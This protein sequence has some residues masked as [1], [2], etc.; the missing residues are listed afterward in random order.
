[1]RADRLLSILM[2]L[3]GRGKMTAQ[4]LSEALDVSERT[5][6][7]DIDA[8]CTSG[9]PVYPE[10]GPGGGFALLES[11]RTNLTGLTEGE[12][13]ALFMLNVPSPLEKLGVSQELQ[14]ALLKLEAAQPTARK[15]ASRKSGA[16]DQAQNR[17]LID[18]EGFFTE[19]PVPHLKLI[20]EAVWKNQRLLLSYR[21][22]M[23][24]MVNDSL[25]DPY[26]LV[27]KAGE[28][29]VI[30]MRAGRLDTLRVAELLEVKPS[31][32][33][34]TRLPGFDLAV[35][36]REWC[37]GYQRRQ[38]R[39]PVR[40]RFAPGFMPYLPLYFG[41]RAKDWARQAAPDPDGWV[42]LT[43]E[44]GSLENARGRLL[45][46]GRAVE[47]LDPLALRRSLIDY[48]R[49]IVALYE[50]DGEDRFTSPG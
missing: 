49:Q 10:H 28:W 6:Y 3:Q 14:S 35:Y 34:F 43:I 21:L 7:R 50:G 9:V 29:F 1:M 13:S 39:Y 36:W 41:Q 8:L 44:F 33:T 15:S 22:I 37:Q 16:E 38:N 20:Q 17:F 12:M 23:G 40:L 45:G 30:V 48:A 32:E 25:V 42:T 27:A 18:W 5:I 24:V 4:E 2:L 47:V 19:E 46:L 31:G 11:Y 26:A